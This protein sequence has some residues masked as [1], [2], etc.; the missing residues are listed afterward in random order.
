MSEASSRREFLACAA[1]GC[2]AV[3]GAGC[4][5][6]DTVTVG[7]DPNQQP[8]GDPS[9]YPDSTRPPSMPSDGTNMPT[10]PSGTT[11]VAGPMVSSLGVNEM[12]QVS[13]TLYVTRDSQGIYAIDIRCT[14]AGCTLNFMA[15][16]ATWRCPCHQSLFLLDGTVVGGPALE[17]KKSLPRYYACRGSDGLVRIDTTK[18]V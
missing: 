15:D 13:G 3:A 17:L 16:S 12:R 2:A 8:I 5:T 9:L 6:E 18:R 1:A 7:G 10:C 11:L 14:H 4:G